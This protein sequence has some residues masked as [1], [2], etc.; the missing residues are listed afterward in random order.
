MHRVFKMHLEF[1]VNKEKGK[2]L[3]TCAARAELLIG[4]NFRSDMVWTHE[5]SS[6]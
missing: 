2:G 1:Q 5:F 3:K 6:I 4:E